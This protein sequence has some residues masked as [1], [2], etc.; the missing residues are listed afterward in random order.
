MP[1]DKDLAGALKQAK[2]RTMNFALV[3]KKKGEGTLIVNSG[4]VKSSAI[5]E[6]EKAIG[7][8]KTYKGKCFTDENTGELMFETTSD[9]PSVDTLKAV[10][11]RDAGMTLKVNSRKET[12]AK[13]LDMLGA[14]LKENAQ[15]RLAGIEGGAD[16]KK[17]MSLGGP[18]A[19]DLKK[20]VKEI[21]NLIDRNDS[22][23][24]N[25]AMDRLDKVA[26]NPTQ[27]L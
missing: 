7:G 8:T 17:A 20:R 15:K 23:K 21:K 19:D 24:A 25:E 9:V 27:T 16:F 5:A 4:D 13:V 22:K 1:I 6:A 11:K 10:I 12:A 18:V 26:K 2:T 14:K 3:E